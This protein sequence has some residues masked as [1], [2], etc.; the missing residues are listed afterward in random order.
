MIPGVYTIILAAIAGT[1]TFLGVYLG[2]KVKKDTKKI[3]FGAS[4]AAWVMIL[5]SFFELIPSAAKEAGLPSSIIWIL[6]GALAVWLIN[7]AIPHMHSVKEIE[8]CSE[9]CLMKMSYLIAVGLILHDLPEGFAIAST[10]KHSSSLGF[11]VVAALFIHN[12]PEG[13]VLTIASSKSKGKNFYYKS[14][15]YSMLATLTGA[16]LGVAL[17]SKFNILNPILISIAAGAMLFIS[18]HELIPVGIR[19]RQAIPA[20]QGMS[21][22]IAVY[23]GLS[24]L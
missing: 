22:A 9:R 24:F 4:F 18:F 19:Y 2:S 21:A 13:Y 3:V 5:I 14:A 1:A 17:I 16:V 11:I 20:L 8:K 12:I 15:A 10:F 7:M 23:F 6:A